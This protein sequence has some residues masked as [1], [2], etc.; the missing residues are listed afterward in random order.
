VGW[1]LAER[2]SLFARANADV[3]LALA[4]VHHLAIGG[5]VPLTHIAATL[6]RLGRRLIAE[7]VPKEDPQV[8]RMLTTRRDVFVDY[9]LEAFRSALSAHFGV[10]REEA[11]PGTRRT[12]LALERR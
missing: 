1:D 4:L 11:I 6:G 7:F 9:S 2:P 3:V 5:N 8:I 10:V 12:L